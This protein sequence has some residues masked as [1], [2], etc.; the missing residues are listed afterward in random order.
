M[1]RPLP[2]YLIHVTDHVGGTKT[3]PVYAISAYE[4]K[5]KL[6]SRAMEAVALK[7]SDKGFEA[8]SREKPLNFGETLDNQPAVGEGIVYAIHAEPG[9]HGKV[10][11]VVAVSCVETGI[12][13]SVPRVDS[14]VLQTFY[15]EEVQAAE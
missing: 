8:S 10:V 2:L 12:V 1:S 11:N 13:R 5:K 14:V 3:P 4:A 9:N 15:I 6:I 7:A